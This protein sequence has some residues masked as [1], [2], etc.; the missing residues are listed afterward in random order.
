MTC[1]PARMHSIACFAC[2]CVGVARIAASTPGCARHS[3]RLSDQCGILKRS[4]TSRVESGLPPA[5]D[6]TSMPGMFCS[7]SRCF[8]PNAPCP[9]TQI[10]M[11]LSSSLDLSG[12]PFII[13]LNGMTDDQRE[14]RQLIDNWVLWRDAG[15]WDRFATVWHDDG[16][17]T[18]TWFQG[19]ASRFIEISREGFERGVNIL[20]FQ[21]AHTA[22]V[23][24]ARAIAQT[25]MQIHQR[26]TVD[27]GP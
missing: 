2:I 15:F 4:A 14:I 11:S 13:F 19:P 21:G 25:K 10:F 5:R 17:M 26:A 24:G 9:A 22:D 16:W 20:H 3:V 8:T 7:A 1:L 6:T 27:G 23:A 18:A 12:T